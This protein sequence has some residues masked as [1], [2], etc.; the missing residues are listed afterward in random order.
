MAG[1]DEQHESPLEFPCEFPVKIMGRA[2]DDFEALVFE[3]VSRHDP[4]L[5]S[6]KISVRASRDGNF[7]AITAVIVA[8]SR[9]QLDEL[10]SELSAHERILMA[11]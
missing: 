8:R 7:V 6:E 3:I 2:A 4:D 1:Q 10:Y 9:E 11:L 5:A